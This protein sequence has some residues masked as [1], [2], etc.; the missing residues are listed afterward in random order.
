MKDYEILYLTGGVIST[1]LQLVVIVA[2]GILLFKKRSLAAGLMFIGS[3]L[4]VLFY[5]FSLFGSTLVARQ[6]AED[7]VKF[8]AIFSI[9]NQIPHMLFAIG[10]LLFIIGYVK[11]GNDSKNI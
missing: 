5:G 11:K 2:T 8:N 3:L 4:T 6:G 1:I 10:L 7:L 9:V